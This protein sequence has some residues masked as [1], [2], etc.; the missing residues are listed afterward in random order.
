MQSP[1]NI[2]LENVFYTIQRDILVRLKLIIIKQQ[3]RIK[4]DEKQ[5]ND[6]S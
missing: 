5:N 6:Q 2:L 4:D 1:K 3:N